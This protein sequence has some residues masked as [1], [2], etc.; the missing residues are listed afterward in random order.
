MATQDAPEN[1]MRK[2]DFAIAHVQTRGYTLHTGAYHWSRFYVVRVASTSRAGLVKTYFDNAITSA[3][4]RVDSTRTV[5]ALP[6]GMGP[7]TAEKMWRAQALDFP[8]YEDKEALRAAINEAA[9]G[10]IV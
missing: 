3:P 1:P 6:T 5:Y 9:G 8:G 7:D 4:K 2:G 10:K